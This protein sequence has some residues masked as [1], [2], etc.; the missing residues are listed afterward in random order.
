MLREQ[1]ST[2]ESRSAHPLR[3]PQSWETEASPASLGIPQSLSTSP[4]LRLPAELRNIIYDL[5][6][7]FQRPLHP[8]CDDETSVSHLLA[9]NKQI[10][11]ETRQLFDAQNTF[12]FTLR[13]YG[14]DNSDLYKLTRSR[15][16]T[17]RRLKLTLE[18]KIDA[19]RTGDNVVMWNLLPYEI[20][21]FPHQLFHYATSTLAGRTCAH[22]GEELGNFK[23]LEVLD[24]KAPQN[25]FA[26]HNH[27]FGKHFFRGANQCL[28]QLLQSPKGQ[29]K[30]R[31]DYPAASESWLV[32][33]QF[34][35]RL[36][37]WIPQISAF[38]LMNPSGLVAERLQWM[39][40]V[41]RSGSWQSS[42]AGWAFYQIR[43]R[44][45]H[46]SKTAWTA[47][48]V[49]VWVPKARVEGVQL[50]DLPTNT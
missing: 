45:Q 37:S 10:Y 33:Y 9:A 32:S 47:M 49:D 31:L 8:C 18:D 19:I 30:W 4:F 50:I 46:D 42:L 44:V 23:H 14:V 29:F 38:D 27:F 39:R 13:P 11:S 26:G 36:A 5:V 35:P 2:L 34:N 17:I 16:E 41:K 28:G 20:R 25:W 22:I 7:V 43:G 1:K 15:N 12:H 21:C 40:L 3:A 24:V 48:E 6:L